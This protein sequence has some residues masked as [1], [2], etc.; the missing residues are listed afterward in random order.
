MFSSSPELTLHLLQCEQHHNLICI[1]C[2]S[3]YWHR[4]WRTD[5]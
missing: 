2:K 4:S 3:S 1:D 5:I